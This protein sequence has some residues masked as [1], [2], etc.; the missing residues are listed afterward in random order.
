MPTAQ[1]LIVITRAQL[2]IQ[3]QLH[4]S[5]VLPSLIKVLVILKAATTSVQSLVNPLSEMWLGKTTKTAQGQTAIMTIT[6][7]RGVKV[8]EVV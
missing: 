7:M 5:G 1:F 3:V 6:L 8:S 4:K 2:S